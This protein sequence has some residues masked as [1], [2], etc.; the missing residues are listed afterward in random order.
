MP[1][2]TGT[3]RVTPRP[4]P[5]A[6]TFNDRFLRAGVPTLT[7]LFALWMGGFRGAGGLAGDGALTRWGFLGMG[8]FTA[9]YAWGWRRG[10]DARWDVLTLAA[11]TL[12]FLVLS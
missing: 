12:M 6:D 10:A 11:L 8:L 4:R 7:W 3:G 1:T 2:D 5:P 9:L